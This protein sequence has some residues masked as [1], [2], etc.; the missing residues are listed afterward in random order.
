MPTLNK[1]VHGGQIQSISKLYQI[2]LEEWLDLSTG[3]SPHHYPIIDIPSTYWHNLPENNNELIEA[4]KSYYQTPYCIASHGS[5]AIIERLPSLWKKQ[6][7]H[8]QHVYL[9]T[10]GYKEHQQAWISSGFQANYY[11]RALPQTIEP[12]SVVIVINP[13]NPTG[14][15]FT[16]NVLLNL[17]KKVQQSKGLLVIDEA[18]MDVISP[19]QSLAPITD[20]ENLIVLRSIGKFFGLAGARIGFTCASTHW[21]ALINQQ[22]GPWHVNGPAQYLTIK[23]LHDTKWQ[24]NQRERLQTL[25]TAMKVVL[26][27]HLGN[28]LICTDLFITV[29]LKNAVNIHHLL[30]LSAVYVR[31]TDEKDALRFGITTPEQLFKLTDVLS[32]LRLS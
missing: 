17:Y 4:A 29:Y 26:K 10:F 5:Q 3:I 20:Q 8:S 24:I 27:K 12:H 13:N 28:N 9:P 11:K 22:L 18:F 6:S 1:L 32:K 2:P 23:A 14:Q 19:S 31:L 21:I 30:C 15:L 25:S 7:P 16:S